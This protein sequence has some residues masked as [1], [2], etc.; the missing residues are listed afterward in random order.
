MSAEENKA[1][2][3][4]YIEE[5]WHQGNMASLDAI[6][7]DDYTLHAPNLPGG[8]LDKQGYRQY[9]QELRAAFPDLR[10]T[11]EA[12][13]VDGDMVIWRYTATGTQRGSY[14]G[15][16]ATDKS[17]QITGIA[18]LRVAGGQCHEAWDEWDSLGM[19]QQLGVLPSMEQM[20]SASSQ[21][22]TSG[23]PAPH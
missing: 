18:I 15:I 22:P 11:I 6:I 20:L 12:L 7:A 9:V 21:G 17:G 3:R 19:L 8:M 23:A 13:Y 4:R 5:I 10:Y 14:M 16:P 1:V 2:V